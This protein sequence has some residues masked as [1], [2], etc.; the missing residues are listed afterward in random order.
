MM[1]L[2]QAEYLGLPVLRRELNGLILTEKVFPASYHLPT[3]T[4][5]KLCVCTILQGTMHE[6]GKDSKRV[7]N[8]I[9]TVF[10]PAGE[11]HYDKFGSD[12]T[13]VVS[14]E[15]GQVWQERLRPY[16]E[17]LERPRQH[18]NDSVTWLGL[19]IHR[20]FQKFDV[21]TPLA[22]EALALELVSRI[23]RAEKPR[24]ENE[25]PKWLKRIEEFL[26]EHFEDPITLDQLS[27]IA[28]VHGVHLIRTFRKFHGTTVGEYLRRRRIEFACKLLQSSKLSVTQVAI[29]AGFYDQSHFT[30]TFRSFVGLTP[31]QFRSQ[32]LNR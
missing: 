31:G 12:E 20:E 11:I 7:F 19:N 2:T 23:I 25:A 5:E 13:H 32:F 21:A 27:Q 28:G 17:W 16:A 22:V 9:T 3:H 26:N 10:H 14:L 1:R 4:H 8:A 6:I 15:F 29:Q 24:K 30:R 18:Q